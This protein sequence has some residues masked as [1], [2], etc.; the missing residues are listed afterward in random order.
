MMSM[1]SSLLHPLAELRS[2][3]EQDAGD[4]AEVDRD[5]Q[6][7]NKRARL[8]V[9]GQRR[10]IGRGWGRDR[11]TPPSVASLEAAASIEPVASRPNDAEVMRVRAAGG[12]LDS[13]AYTCSCGYFFD[14]PVS[15]SV[16]CPHCGA[17]QAW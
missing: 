10:G 8:R 1:R 2:E 11:A 16:P 7:H 14:A 4:G 17:V 13:A 12:P 3:Q 15:T 6:A 5:S 9:R